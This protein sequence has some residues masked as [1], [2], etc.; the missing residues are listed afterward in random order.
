MGLLFKHVIGL[1]LK[2]AMFSCRG[3]HAENPRVRDRLEHIGRTFISGYNEALKTSETGALTRQ[4]N[5]SDAALRGFAYEGAAMALALLDNMTP[6][7]TKRVQQFLFGPAA[8]HIYMAHV[9]VGWAIGRLPWL[10]KSLDRFL[11]QLDPLLRWLAIDGYGFH[12]GYFH[13][14]RQ[15]QAQRY[16]PGLTQ[17][18]QRAFDQGLGRSLWFVHGAGVGRIQKTIATFPLSRQVDLWAG[19][20]LAAAYAGSV[21]PATLKSLKQV[22]GHYLP[23]LAQGAAF[24]ARARQLAGNP[25][26]HTGLAC[27][28][29]CGLSAD[30][31]AGVTQVA[32]IDLPPDCERAPAYEIWRRRIQSHFSHQTISV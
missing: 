9:G 25:A 16:P 18:A 30:E 23:Q 27:E 17:Y 32:L 10:R 28:I 8:H 4:L 11:S 26:E 21:G 19:I 2:E 7:N 22:S 1:S 3:F 13:W 20:G 24:A 29:F 15:I 12:E 31:S 5:N 6:W 14:Q